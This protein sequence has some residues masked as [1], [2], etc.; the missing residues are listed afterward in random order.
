MLL[1]VKLQVRET[2][3]L[4]MRMEM[5]QD[6]YRHCASAGF[7]LG[8]TMV[9]H[10]ISLPTYLPLTHKLH[11][12]AAVLQVLHLN[13]PT[14]LLFGRTQHHVLSCFTAKRENVKL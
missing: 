8:V 4:W 7:P 11:T 2:K 3:H 1:V 5:G 9:T 10:P 6:T 12:F 13:A 14:L